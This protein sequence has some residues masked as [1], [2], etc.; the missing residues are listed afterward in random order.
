M[1]IEQKYMHF[2]LQ[3]KEYDMPKYAIYTIFIH[4]LSA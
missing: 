4:V 1:H 3:S 2:I